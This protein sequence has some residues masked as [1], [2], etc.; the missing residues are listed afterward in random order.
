MIPLISF[1]YNFSQECVVEKVEKGELRDLFVVKMKCGE[2]VMSLDVVSFINIFKEGGRVKTIISK[3]LPQYSPE[4]F[5][6][7]GHVVTEK[8]DGFVTIIS[9][10]GP[11]LRISSKESFLKTA[12]L[13]VMDH[14]YFCASN[15]R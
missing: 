3:E 15:L 2:I 1:T 13:N 9:F 10:F 5:C 7:H 6:A 12:N 8:K 11:L 4:D 14:V